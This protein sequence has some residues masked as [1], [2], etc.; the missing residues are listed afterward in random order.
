M[1]TVSA[2]WKVG[3]Q[4]GY[5][6]NSL[7]ANSGYAYDRTYGSR[8][9]FTVGVPVRYEFVDWFALQA[10]VSYTQKIMSGS[11]MVIMPISKAN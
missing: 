3:V 6:S 1:S 8:G 11:V 5:T 10:E 7:S 4:A 9:G 2:Q